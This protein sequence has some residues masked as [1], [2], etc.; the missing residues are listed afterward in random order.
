MDE[1]L[2]CGVDWS[3]AYVYEDY[4]WCTNGIRDIPKVYMMVMI[5]WL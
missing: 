2:P 4:K 3:S 5:D 1:D